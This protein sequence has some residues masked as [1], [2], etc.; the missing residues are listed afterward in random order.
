MGKKFFQRP[1]TQF[2]LITRESPYLARSDR[3]AFVSSFGVGNEAIFTFADHGASGANLALFSRLNRQGLLEKIEKL[4][5]QLSA[6]PGE[7]Q[8]VLEEL[9]ALTQQLSSLT[10]KSEQRQALRERKEQRE[11]QLYRLLPQ[12]KHRVVEVEQV[13]KALPSDGLLIE[14][15]RYKPFDGKKP[16]GDHWSFARY[17][18]MVLK[19]NG[20]VNVVDLGDAAVLEEVITAAVSTAR[21]AQ[22]DAVQ[23]F[24]AVSQLVLEPL[25][26][27]TNG[28]KTWFVSPD[29]ELNRLP[30]LR[31]KFR[32]QGLFSRSVDLRL[33]D[34]SGTIG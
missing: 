7:H 32:W 20:S 23:K 30:F 17:L 19:P 21:Q 24:E 31:C 16:M 1:Y 25:K 5:G 34:R 13:A 6:L 33:S 2:R 27:A 14:F 11:K 29:G 28:A 12:L 15:Q 4:Q 22:E 26:Q 3:L 18:A 9:R 8:Q 10:K